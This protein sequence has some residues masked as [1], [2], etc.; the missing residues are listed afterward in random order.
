MISPDKMHLL[1]THWS[2]LRLCTFHPLAN[3]M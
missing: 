1:H 3:L 2:R